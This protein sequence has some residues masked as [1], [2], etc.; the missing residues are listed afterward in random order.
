MALQTKTF[1][2]GSYEWGSESNAYVLELTLTEVDYSIA[3]NA[4][5]V[6]YALV[7]KSGNQNRFTGQIDSV[8][9]LA[10]EEVASGSKQIS[11]AYNS[12]WT[13]LEGTVNVTHNAD[14]SLNMPIV[15]SINTYNNYAPPDK[16]LEWSWQLTDI[17]RA[18]SFGTITG[19]TLGGKMRVNINRNSEDFSHIVYYYLGNDA[20]SGGAGGDTSV[21]IDLPMDLAEMSPDSPQFNLLLLLRTY[22]G[23]TRIGEDVRQE[24]SISIPDNKETKPTVSMKL[25]PV[26]FDEVYLQ[27]KTRVKVYSF[28][29]EGQY[30]AQIVSRRWNLEGKTYEFGDTSDPLIGTGKI[31]VE[32][33]VVDSRGFSNSVKQEIQ[34]TEYFLPILKADAYRCLADGTPNDAGEFL[35]IRASA[36]IASVG[37]YNSAA[38]YYCYR[39][40]SAEQYSNP[41]LLDEQLHTGDI[42]ETGALLEGN[43]LKVNAYSVLIIVRDIVGEQAKSTIP[44]PS[45][46][47][48]KHKKA[49]G[50]GMGLGGYCDQDDLLD[51]HW[52]GR[53]RKGLVLGN[54]V[55]S[56]YISVT[57]E[58]PAGTFGG[59]WNRVT[60]SVPSVIKMWIRTQ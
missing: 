42:V 4:S 50:K 36:E 37:G 2:W 38:L 26:G 55:G 49:G 53:I 22:S 45:E 39:S 21:E 10:G 52:N 14:G 43:L 59:V 44:I 32:G 9:E 24:V 57:E 30:G 28:D 34:V 16:T 48:Y 17:P 20:W 56:V 11:K 1:T 19:T 23:E 54:G 46:R 60:Q 35:K 5:A 41:I 51:V 12:S 58:D 8:L 27:R 15:V 7:L 6:S 25:E 40:E 31:I 13:L 3:L 33:V 18:S 47:I 29:A